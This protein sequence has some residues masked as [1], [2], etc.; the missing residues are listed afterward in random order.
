MMSTNM[1]DQYSIRQLSEI[2]GVNAVT[3]RAWERRYGL[4]KPSRTAKGHR[5][6]TADDID[7]VRNILNWLDRGVAISKVRPMLDSEQSASAQPGTTDSNSPDSHWQETIGRS[8]E[9]AQ[10]FQREKLE[11]QLNELFGNYPLDTLTNNY[12]SPVRD[13]LDRQAQL[14]FGANAER[15]FF[16][17]E[18]HADLM[19][20]IR[21]TNSNNNG[22]RLLLL[23]F[24]GQQHSIHA[25]LLALALLE[26]GFRLHFLFEACHLREI[27]YIIEQSQI[28]SNSAIKAVIC[29]SSSKPDIL[30]IE[31]E[32]ARAATHARVPFFLSGE[33]IN[34]I[35]SL[36]NIEGITALERPLRA[37][38]TAISQSLGKSV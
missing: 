16:D 7:T 36:R 8:L 19:S 18:L 3:I 31:Q 26:A 34:I 10:Q 25:L 5:Y 24:D 27:P 33:W 20:R 1:A 2:S 6:Y 35:P 11:Q 12:F 14:R 15:I 13:A 4:L 28:S 21:H 22:E 17:S 32:L 29:H 30:Q 9:L 37:S 23:A 38:V